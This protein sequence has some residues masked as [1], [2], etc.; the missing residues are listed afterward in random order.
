[1]QEPREPE[2]DC[3][4][5]P[6]LVDYRLENCR[7]YPDF[8]NAPVSSFGDIGAE[9]LIV[10]LAPGVKGANQTGRPFTGDYAGDLLYA[11]LLKFG[12]AHGAYGARSDDGLSLQNC[13]ITNAVKCVPPQNKP[14]GSEVNA[15]RAFLID[16]IRAMGNL[17]ILFALGGLAHGAILST[18]GERKSVFW[19]LRC[20]L[21]LLLSEMPFTQ[22]ISSKIPLHAHGVGLQG[23][24]K[25]KVTT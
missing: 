19:R 13:R 14:V 4:L 7:S 18:L 24:V 23:G 22:A 25:C 11:T 9:L 16:E 8:H 21:L 5:C 1:M 17:K 10:G 6:R 2:P 15:C 3:N 12:F 20:L